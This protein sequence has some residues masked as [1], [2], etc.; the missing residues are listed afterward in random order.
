MQTLTKL[1]WLEGKWEEK[2][3]LGKGP[4][5]CECFPAPV[6]SSSF[7]LLPLLPRARA[8]AVDVPVGGGVDVM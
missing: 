2:G 7:S 4:N 6:K 8:V 5:F 1:L 3:E